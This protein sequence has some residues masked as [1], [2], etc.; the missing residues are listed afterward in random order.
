[1]TIEWQEFYA[2]RVK[3]I[4]GSQ[5][6]NF[7]RLTERP[8]V[9]SFAGGFPGSEFFPR[10]DIARTLAELV[11]EEGRYAL[12]YGPTEGNYEL[13]AYLAGK[14]RREGSPCELENIIITDGSQQALDLLCRILVDPGDPVLV[15][16]PAY[17]GAMGAIQSYGGAPAGITMDPD[18][19]LP[20]VME[21]TLQQLALQGKNPKLF[22]TVSNFQNPTGYTTSLARRRAVLELANRYNLLIIEDNPYGELVYEGEVPPT[23]KSL[24][25]SGRVIYL[26]SYSKTFIP[27]IRIGWIAGAAPLLEKVVLAKQTTDL[28]SSSLGQRLAYALSQKGYVDAHVKRL[29]GQ[30]RQKR[31]AMLGAMDQYFPPEIGFSRPKGGF[32]V[33]VSFPA[34]YPPANDLLMLALERKVAFVHGEGFFS[35][36]GGTHTA[37]FSFSQPGLEDIVKG[38]DRLGELFEQVGQKTLR[39][40]AG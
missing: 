26:G 12:Q 39:R 21:R 38:I 20:D 24:D 15:E 10:E 36:G 17:I 25:R 23:Y 9:I 14:M 4:T 5:I 28:C 18:G 31:D 35:N 27:G 7:F 22:Y 29:V 16:E 19:P 32:F 6:R 1:M 33:W 30:Y 37:R 13:R 8:E 40:A 3:R 2:G 11:R 34:H